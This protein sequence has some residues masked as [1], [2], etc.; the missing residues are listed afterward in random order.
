MCRLDDHTLLTGDE[1]GLRKRLDKLAAEVSPPSWKAA[2]QQVDGGL[3]T[4]VTTFLQVNRPFQDDAEAEKGLT[5]LFNRQL[6][7]GV[8]WPA[9]AGGPPIVKVRIRCE[10]ADDADQ[11]RTELQQ[12][13]GL[14][15]RLVEQQ[16]PDHKFDEA[17]TQIARS[18]LDSLRQVRA[19]TQHTDAGWQLAAD[20]ACPWE[21]FAKF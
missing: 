16:L 2:W 9:A 1:A 8:D 18:L 6:A 3:I 11:L 4:L 10:S 21:Y 5:N 19:E 12:L 13:R 20:F 17:E 7:V 14:L 15:E